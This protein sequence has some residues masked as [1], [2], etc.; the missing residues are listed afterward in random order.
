MQ[1]AVPV[2]QEIDPVR[3][4]LPPGLH[5]APV[6][7]AVQVPLLH[8][9]LVPQGVPGATLL[10]AAHV[11]VPVAHDVVPVTHGFPPGAQ[12]APWVHETQAPPLQTRFCP[13]D[14]PSGAFEPVSLHAIPASEHWIEPTL[15]EAVDGTQG[16]PFAH[17]WQ[18]PALQYMF[19]PHPV[20]LGAL[21]AAVHVA[22]PVAHEMACAW[23]EPASLQSAP[24]P[25]DTHPPLS[26]TAPASH[27]VPFPA[28]PTGMHIGWPDD[29][30]V[31]T[32]F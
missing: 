28:V 2:V 22:T 3:Q 15:H 8:T 12:E 25:Q 17:T 5:A 4:G 6:A 32:P 24:A 29:V 19:G 9:S 26:H 7:H 11:A 18:D 14:V 21:P 31:T 30:H 10:P 13:H 20:P 1:T 27:V 16:D 23:H